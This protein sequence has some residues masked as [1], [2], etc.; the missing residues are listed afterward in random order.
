MI[1]W[2]L[3]PALAVAEAVYSFNMVAEALLEHAATEDNSDWV[4][5]AVT[6]THLWCCFMEACIL[7]HSRKLAPAALLLTGPL[8]QLVAATLEHCTATKTVQHVRKRLMRLLCQPMFVFVLALAPSAHPGLRRWLPSSSSSSSS[9]S[10][11]SPQQVEVC[12]ANINVG[13]QQQ[14]RWAVW[15]GR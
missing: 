9:S 5:T 1:I 15:P 14:V 2:L 3:L 10:R 13:L 12:G 7:F 11:L 8:L 6:L 4:S